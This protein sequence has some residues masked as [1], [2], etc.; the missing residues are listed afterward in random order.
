MD[1][2]QRPGWSTGDL[3]R[4]GE[5]LVIDRAATP[6]GCPPYGEV[7]LWHNELAT[8][9]AIR[10]ATDLWAATPPDQLSITARAKTVDTLVQKL[11]RQTTLKLGQVQDLAG[12]RVDADMILTQQTE[13]AEDIAKHFGAARPKIKDMRET[14]HSGYRAVHVWLALPAGRVEVQIRTLAQ[15]EWA[16]L[17]EDVGEMFGRGIRYG[18]KHKNADVQSVIEFI[19][20]MSEDIRVHEMVVDAEW[21]LERFAEKYDSNTDAAQLVEN[22]RSKFAELSAEFPLGRSAI[23]RTIPVLREFRRSLQEE[24]EEI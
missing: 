17:Y 15:S 12:V 10:I 18:E 20:A 23:E 8:E 14:P 1:L 7:M 3:R 9:V 13:I 2:E 19:H 16:N 22:W 11:Q 4:L 21:Q 24:E 6:D 5:A